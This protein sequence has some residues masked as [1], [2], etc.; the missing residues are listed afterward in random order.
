M[1]DEQPNIQEIESEN[2]DAESAVEA[3]NEWEYWPKHTYRRCPR[4]YLKNTA[5]LE[6]DDITQQSVSFKPGS[7]AL[8][9]KDDLGKGYTSYE[10]D[11]Q[12]ILEPGEY[13]I[14]ING[15]SIG[16]LKIHHFLYPAAK[17]TE[18]G[19]VPQGEIVLGPDNR[20]CFFIDDQCKADTY[21]NKYTIKMGNDSY[22]LVPKKVSNGNKDF[23]FCLEAA[24]ENPPADDHIVKVIVHKQGVDE[25]IMKLKLKTDWTSENKDKLKPLFL[26]FLRDSYYGINDVSN[27][28]KHIWD[29]I[30]D[31]CLKIYN[32]DDLD[33]LKSP[34]QNFLN[35]NGLDV[36]SVIRSTGVEYWDCLDWPCAI[37]QNDFGSKEKFD[38]LLN[39]LPSAEKSPVSRKDI[40]SLYGSNDEEKNEIKDIKDTV[41]SKLPWPISREILLTK[42]LNE[43]KV[44]GN[45]VPFLLLHLHH[46]V[47]FPLS[48]GHGQRW[49]SGQNKSRHDAI[50]EYCGIEK[51]LEGDKIHF[52]VWFWQTL[53]YLIAN[54][55]EVTYWADKVK[56]DLHFDYMTDVVVYADNPYKGGNEMYARLRDQ[57][58]V[59]LYG[60]PGTGKTWRANHE[61]RWMIGWSL[62]RFFNYNTLP[63]SRFIKQIQFHPSYSYEDFIQG[64]RP[65]PKGGAL[66][67]K[68]QD[69]HFKRFCEQAG[70]V[71]RIILELRKRA[72]A[73]KDLDVTQLL[74]NTKNDLELFENLGIKLEATDDGGLLV[75]WP[76]KEK[77]DAAST[78]S[79]TYKK[80][81]EKLVSNP[82][83]FTFD[84]ANLPFFVFI[85]DEINR[86]NLAAVLGELMY[87]LEYRGFEHAR[88]LPLAHL[89]KDEI[90]THASQ[91]FFV[92]RNV[93]VVGTMNTID[94]ST[95]RVDFALR[96]R[97]G[98]WK[99]DPQPWLADQVMRKKYEDAKNDPANW[100]VRDLLDELNKKIAGDLSLLGGDFQIG[101]SY[102]FNLPKFGDSREE[103]LRKLWS[104]QLAP[105]LEDF[106]GDPKKW[107]KNEITLREKLGL[108]PGIVDPGFQ[109]IV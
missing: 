59:I 5:S 39:H 61:S 25:A 42:W 82:E 66:A 87:C 108:N 67:F 38:V 72:E 81:G 50:V 11:P 28:S 32:E 54:D 92:P 95:E 36:W 98:W 102:F 47:V 4:I 43:S 78:K 105:L 57:K 49:V 40:A 89:V 70:V 20:L 91:L 16:A 77:P 21:D 46:P 52:S 56:D 60:P 2:H 29:K 58:Q 65:V 15:S 8:T 71:E 23:L 41:I 22:D 84:S 85:I 109:T 34:V 75:S 88:P 100:K 68:V 19:G 74:E 103:A 55:P 24:V 62:A 12:V 27:L 17:S 45:K 7:F 30:T 106:Y 37:A 10:P 6:P 107:D 31:N 51:I 79:V 14:H 97:F 33:N 48:S 86:A 90:F 13:E 99:C 1:S 83:E 69:G 35:K 63:S 104:L 96:R 53:E 18:E 26:S 94:K 3:G 76:E 64:L 73:G 44:C 101:E 9:K 93:Y 80:D